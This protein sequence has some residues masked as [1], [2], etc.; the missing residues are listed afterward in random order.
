MGYT[1]ADAMTFARGVADCHIAWFEEPV[2][3]YDQV[4]GMHEVRAATGIRV[5]AGQSEMQRWGC[6]DLVEGGAVD[7]LNTDLSLAGGHR[8]A[9]CG[10]ACG[11]PPGADGP[12]RRTASRCTS[13]LRPRACTPNIF[14]RSATPWGHT[15]L[16][17][18][19]P[20]PGLGRVTKPLALV[21]RWTRRLCS[22]IAWI[23]DRLPLPSQGEGTTDRRGSRKL[24]DPAGPTTSLPKL[25][26]NHLPVSSR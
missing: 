16:P 14:R 2:H 8:M 17:W 25:F 22:A 10:G 12:P 6:R 4:R 1:V 19:H 13:W 21:S 23:G 11:E 5:T 7:I 3:W 26:P 15:C 20:A 24:H 9:A 18:P